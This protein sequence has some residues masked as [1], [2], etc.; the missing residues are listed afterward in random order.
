MR[1]KRD[2]RNLVHWH[3]LAETGPVRWE[4]AGLADEE[5]VVESSAESRKGQVELQYLA[6][7]DGVRGK[8]GGTHRQMNRTEWYLAS[9]AVFPTGGSSALFFSSANHNLFPITPG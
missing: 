8:S 7:T 1:W 2:A 6:S 4:G 9:S 5:N 3:V